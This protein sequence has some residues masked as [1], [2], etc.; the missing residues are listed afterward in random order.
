MWKNLVLKIKS[1]IDFQLNASWIM[2]IIWL[3]IS[4]INWWK[5]LWQIWK[6]CQDRKIKKISKILQFLNSIKY[7]TG[8]FFQYLEYFL[9]N[10]SCLLFGQMKYSLIT[11]DCILL[12]SVISGWKHWGWGESLLILGYRCKT[13]SVLWLQTQ[14]TG[15]SNNILS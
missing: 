14:H 3:W 10:K 8:F 7:S 15:L 12:S 6:T 13:V 2:F 9:W 1:G 4:F 11:Q 5:V